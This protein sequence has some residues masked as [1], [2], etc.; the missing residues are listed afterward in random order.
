[1]DKLVFDFTNLNLSL[2]LPGDKIRLKNSNDI[3]IKE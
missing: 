1:M 2:P 3:F